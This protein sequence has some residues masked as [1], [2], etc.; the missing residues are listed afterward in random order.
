MATGL[1]SCFFQLNFANFFGVKG[2]LRLFFLFFG[3]I[4]RKNSHDFYCQHPNF[5]N[6]FNNLYNFQ[7]RLFS[8]WPI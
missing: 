7:K 8:Y 5:G 1:K 3:V 2:I 6:K 4:R